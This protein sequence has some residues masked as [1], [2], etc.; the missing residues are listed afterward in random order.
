MET[1]GNTSRDD[2]NRSAIKIAFQNEIECA[3]LLL[4][5]LDLEYT[6][7][8][9]QHTEALEE[10]VREKQEKIQ[11]LESYSIHREKL[12]SQFQGVTITLSGKNKN[13]QF[14]SDEELTNLWNKLVEIAET[15]RD[16]NRINGSIVEV[17]SK[18]SKHALEILHGILP[19]SSSVSELYNNA[20]QTIKSSDKRSL[21]QV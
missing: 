11:R 12:L 14:S 7:L 16:K 15:C 9:E 19:S 1:F 3:Q 4:Q 20:G 5:S 21:V 2:T 18:Q 8:T 10:V 6:A 13:Y 17:F